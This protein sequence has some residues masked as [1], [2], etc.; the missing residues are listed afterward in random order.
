MNLIILQSINDFELLKKFL[1]KSTELLVFSGNVMVTL[2]Q[3]N[4]KY[5]VIENFYPSGQF[6]K[7]AR[8]Y[9]KKI[10]KLLSELDKTC[11]NYIQFPFAYSGNEPFFLGWF[12]DIVYL[13]KLIEN[14]QKKYKKIYLFSDNEPNQILE[15]H[16][17]FSSFNSRNVNGTISFAREKSKERFIQLIYSSLKIFFI[18]D[19][20]LLQKKIPTNYLFKSFFDKLQY[21]YARRVNFKNLNIN[22]KERFTNKKVYIIQDD[23]ELYPLRKYLPKFD[24]SNPTTKLR[25]ET[26]LENPEILSTNIINK[27]L[28]NFINDNFVFLK[29]YLF[30]FMNSYHFEIVG[31][32]K[33]FKEKFEQQTIK[34]KP[35]LI[36]SSSG[37]RDIFDT[38][39]CYVANKLK[40]PVITFQHAG[41][42]SFYYCPTL[43]SHEYNLRIS[44]TLIAQSKKDIRKLNNKKTKAVCM[45]S[46]QEYEF[47]HI[48]SKK[49]QK[50]ILFCNGP[51]SETRFRL[52]FDNF[53]IN[54]KYKRSYE[55]LSAAD[56]AS[57][58]IDIKLHP[59]DEKNSFWNYKNIIENNLFKKTNLIYGS[60]LELISKNYKLIIIDLL[61]SAMVKHLIC[62][63]VPIIIYAAYFDKLRV[64]K[65]ALTD[66]Y[67]R[68]YIAKNKCELKYL[69]RR[70]KDGK[71]SSKWNKE[72]IDN[73]IY[74]FYKGNPGD[75]ISKYIEKLLTDEK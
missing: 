8:I 60:P 43:K 44:K 11:K 35:I 6:I 36:F 41:T 28:K 56:E 50:N 21:R 5:K 12:D 38:I 10:V 13:E 62:L 46:V 65:V 70:F 67:K 53:S 64:N 58:S 14:I 1:N 16:L 75:N 45:G 72:I 22:A 29:K 9:R 52:L 73:F 55:I 31:R 4:I 33:S 32:I 54:K 20:K 69:L 63:K 30:L 68:F 42:T 2:D 71:L 40:I 66:F 34:D 59:A 15:S 51:E 25:K 61:S 47:T 24:Y 26:R 7:E 17:N 23:Y 39:A 57:L 48:Q 27:I 19:K 3:K 74:P 49:P 37:T 18:K